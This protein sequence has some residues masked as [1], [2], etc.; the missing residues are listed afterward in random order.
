[1]AEHVR[2][3][4][5]IVLWIR[6]PFRDSHVSGG[7][8]KSSELPVGHRESID[9]EVSHDDR[10]GWAL[11]GIVVVRAHHEGAARNKN[12]QTLIGRWRLAAGQLHAGPHQEFGAQG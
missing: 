12:L 3:R 8:D 4:A 1:D 7:L 9:P 2:K 10:V 11:F 5:G 6:R